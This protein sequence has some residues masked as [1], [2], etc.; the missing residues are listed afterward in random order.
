VGG[1]LYLRTASDKSV[2]GLTATQLRDELSVYNKAQVDS[3]AGKAKAG[4][5]GISLTQK[6]LATH[7]TSTPARRDRN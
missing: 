1:N 4:W 6:L 2:L 3:L 5:H 7:R